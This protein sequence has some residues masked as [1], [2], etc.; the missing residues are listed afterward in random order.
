MA[1]TR[2]RVIIFVYGTLKRG[3]PGHAPLRG[4]TFL[5]DARTTSQFTL[6]DCGEWP[7]MVA[8]G[9]GRVSG[10]LFEIPIETLKALDAYE[11]R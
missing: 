3:F 6:Y 7:A 4:A 2:P 5:K 10:E 8:H 11:G 1:L 9:K